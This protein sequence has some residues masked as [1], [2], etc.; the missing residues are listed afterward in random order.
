MFIVLYKNDVLIDS[1]CNIRFDI[2]PPHVI[3]DLIFHPPHVISDFIFDWLSIRTS[4]VVYNTSTILTRFLYKYQIIRALWTKYETGLNYMLTDL[5]M[6]GVWY[7]YKWLTFWK[8]GKGKCLCIQSFC[9][10]ILIKFYK[11]NL[12]S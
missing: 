5:L 12:F 9:K 3:F 6:V 4:L 8:R 10:L 7:K 2:S 11:S 1:P